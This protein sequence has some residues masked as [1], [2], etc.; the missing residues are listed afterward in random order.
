MIYLLLNS[1]ALDPNRWTPAKTAY[2]K[3]DQLL[4]PITEAGFHFV[5]IWGYHI[6]R[7]SENTIINIRKTADSLGL[8]FSIIGIYPILH[9]TGNKRQLEL[10]KVKKI[11]NDA[12][13]LGAKIVKIFV[14]NLSTEKI[15][16]AEYERSV[17]FMSEMTN[18]AKSFGLNLV[19]ETHQK[20]LFDTIESC[21][22]FIKDVGA[23]NFK[24]CFQPYNFY[25]TEQI[26][27]D[28]EV[29][30]DN[31]IHVHYQGRKNKKL[32]LLEYS[33]IDYDILTKELIK[34]GFNGHISIE[35]VKGCVVKKSDDFDLPVVLTNAQQDRDF[36][37]RICNKYGSQVRF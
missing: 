2:Y 16:P 4:K 20:T 6:S 10:E 37:V 22:K 25:H 7:E 23:T 33:D 32:D 19:G 12:Y 35:F 8:N 18:L 1:I 27:Q 11:F 36:I 13:I 14:G 5:E 30:S 24:I 26:L 9:L 31:V 21:G 17:K 29:L 28:Y 15:T 3:F 34:S